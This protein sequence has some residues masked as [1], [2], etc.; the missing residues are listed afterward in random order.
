MDSKDF[1]LLVALH[2]DARASYRSLGRRVS[3]TAPAVRD[4]LRRLSEK[5]ILQG[6]W[7]TPDPGLLGREDLLVFF[8]GEWTRADA[9]RALIAPDVAWVAWKI[10]GS[11]TVQMWP[12]DAERA[13]RDLAHVVGR[14]A[15]GH[16]LADPTPHA[17]VAG[18]DWRI[19]EELVDEPRMPL[20]ELC[21]R[22]G[23]SPK[24]VR[25]HLNGLLEHRAIYITPKLGSLGD[26]GEVVYTLLVYGDVALGEVRK[27]VGD[28]IL[29]NS[30]E[31]P[32]MK[33]MLCRAT[34]L[35]DVTGRLSAVRKLGGVES[36]FVTLNREQVTNGEY[37]HSV[38]REAAKGTSSPIPRMSRPPSPG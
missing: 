35:N 8:H 18:L 13:M 33:Y 31:A 7:M 29:L 1:R 36:A 22:T 9:E 5:G 24:T 27:A 28:G 38:I 25:R 17:P 21:E 19:M 23:L 11:L 32:P 16:T 15:S 37:I 30:A 20:H 6:F 12:R 2:E 10:D 3:L 34:D 26:A 14:P 4:R